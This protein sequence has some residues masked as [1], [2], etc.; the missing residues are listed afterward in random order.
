MA[1]GLNTLNLIQVKGGRIIKQSDTSTPFS[2][3][4]I[5]SVGNEMPLNGKRALV[6]L[7]NPV[8]GTY[9][10]TTVTVRD[11][12][13]EFKMPG[14]LLDDN[15]ILEISCDGYVFP[16][17]NDYI[18]SVKK[19]YAELLDGKTATLYKQTAKEL[20]REAAE[21]AVKE[22]G[23]TEL[24]GNK[25]DRGLKGEPGLSI[26]ITGTKKQGKD[27]IIT[28]SDNTTITVKDGLDGKDGK[29]GPT[30]PQGERGLTGPTGPRGPKGADGVMTFADLTDEQRESLRGPKGER[31]LKGD[32]GEPGPKGERGPQ[33]VS[34]KD[35]T[36]ASVSIVNNLTDGGVDKVLSAEQGKILFQYANDGKEKI[37]KAIVGKGTEAGKNESFDSLASK[38]DTL[39]TGY[40]LGDIIPKDNLELMDDLE[41]QHDKDYELGDKITNYLLK[42]GCIYFITDKNIGYCSYYGDDIWHTSKNQGLYGEYQGLFSNNMGRVYTV[43]E[44]G[45][46]H[47]I[48]NKEIEMI[49][50]MVDITKMVDV[51]TFNKYLTVGSYSAVFSNE[52]GLFYF[53]GQDTVKMDLSY[54]KI[55]EILPIFETSERFYILT[56]KTL[57][58]VNPIWSAKLVQHNKS[59]SLG[60]KGVKGGVYRRTYDDYV[61]YTEN[62]LIRVEKDQVKE[63]HSYTTRISNIAVNIDSDLFILDE[64]GKVNVYGEKITDR[65]GMLDIGPG[66]RDL[67]IDDNNN[68]F[69][70]NNDTE[71]K[72][73][74]WEPGQNHGDYKLV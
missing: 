56:D 4:L 58:L 39:K 9:W 18:I 43:N 26:T 74:H 64:S 25:G 50:S 33:G 66:T 37:A 19:G 15:Y 48:R 10:E 34:G 8:A 70:V 61:F 38:I 45:I 73:Y 55:N 52:D 53:D 54:A 22:L 36:N 35:G 67:Q 57:V 69:V 62:S 3:V 16:S 20:V 1:K 47:L 30:G 11:S 7:R 23:K 6:S 40:S 49:V 42:D 31:G 28:F 44:K 13:V 71:I 72:K 51:K 5:D 59:L 21:R 27:N 12:T 63:R 65:K 60:V 14:N 41:F 17:D 46:A 2:F 68:I 29:T 32:K 24:K